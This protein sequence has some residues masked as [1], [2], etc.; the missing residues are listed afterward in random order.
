MKKTKVLFL[1]TSDISGGAAIACFRAVSVVSKVAELEV[2]LL[3]QEK[4]SSSPFVQ[5][6]A[7]TY[8]AK[9][10]A[11]LR[12][13]R[14]RLGYW[15]Q[16]KSKEVRFAYS[17]ANTGVDISQHPLVQEA[18]IIHL[19]WVH[20]GFLSLKSLEKLANLGKP[21]V[22]TLQDMWSFTGG[23]HYAGDCKGFQHACGNCPFLKNPHAQDLSHQ[24]WKKKASFYPQA[25]WIVTPTSRWL[26]EQAKQSTLFKGMQVEHI[27]API[28]S[29][30]FK[31]ATSRKE[32]RED[33][34]LPENAFILLFGAANINDPR[35]GFQYLIEALKQFSEALSAEERKN[36]LLM[37]FGKFKP[38]TLEGLPFEVKNLGRM[39]LEDLVKVY[40]SATA[41]VMPSLEDNLPN[42]IL[43]SLACGTPV[44]AF[45]S[46]G[47][48]EMITHQKNGYLAD[49]QS[50]IDF[51]KGLK[52]LYDAYKNTQSY[53]YEAYCEA[54]REIIERTYSEEI[55]KEKYVKFYQDLMTDKQNKLPK[56]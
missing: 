51:A 24:V 56:N 10:M 29:H 32:V 27:P 46:G 4:K 33:L 22:W 49:Y 2:N 38:E 20:F 21:L 54:A 41:F 28:D 48:P 25:Q 11:F 23:C 17:P 15:P 47:I 52:W 50:S 12:F 39:N 30:F 5:A 16:A 36:I 37:V 14:E 35:K 45:K 34:H 42:T 53:D 13:V 9:K 31:P 44:I 43:E 8:W 40:Q 3:V 55:I 7:Q 26:T 6:L 1:S 19:H 18:D